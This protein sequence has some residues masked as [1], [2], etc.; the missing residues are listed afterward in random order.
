LGG[1]PGQWNA[2]GGRG[3]SQYGELFPEQIFFGSGGGAGGECN[4]GQAGNGGRGGGIIILFTAQLDGI[5]VFRADGQDGIDGS[6]A[7]SGGGG[8]GGSIYV[9]GLSIQAGLSNNASTSFGESG[10]L[11]VQKGDGKDG[12]KDFVEVE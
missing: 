4:T 10:T 11:G 5:G 6:Q 9:Q 8:S 2:Y 3:G 7:G 12:R 1:E